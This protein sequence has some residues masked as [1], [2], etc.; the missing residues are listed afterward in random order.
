[1]FQFLRKR[2]QKKRLESSDENNQNSNDENR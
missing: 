2:I 1:M